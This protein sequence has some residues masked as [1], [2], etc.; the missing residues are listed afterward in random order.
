MRVLYAPN[1]DN[2]GVEVF[3]N[4]RGT[5]GRFDPTQW[6][7]VY[8]DKPNFDI[9]PAIRRWAVDPDHCLGRPFDGSVGS[10][11]ILWPEPEANQHAQCMLS[12]A[13]MMFVKPYQQNLLDRVNRYCKIFRDGDM[14]KQLR[15]RCSAAWQLCYY[16]S[17]PRDITRQ[18]ATFRRFWFLADAWLECR[19][20]L[21]PDVPNKAASFNDPDLWPPDRVHWPRKDL[22]GAFTTD[23]SVGYKLYHR[24]VPVWLLR[25]P[26]QMTLGIHIVATIV[27]FSEVLTFPSIPVTLFATVPVYSGF[28][29][30]R[31]LK[32][33]FE[34]G[35][36]YLDIEH[37]PFA[38]PSGSS[39]SHT[40]QGV[41]RSGTQPGPRYQPCELS[42]VN[43]S[44]DLTMFLKITPPH[45]RE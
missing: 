13:L 16:A 42:L 7:Q 40:V 23:G 31:L 35:H 5:F 28:V 1:L 30:A 14:L 43:V 10:T 12:P 24:G 33:I 41:E 3:Q 6:P 37:T 26:S 45:L 38:A 29:G 27:P 19:V 17:T 44:A 11:D 2:I 39:S 4:D 9:L 32:A 21:F 25:R 22:M 15:D 18:F 34:N 36:R 8:I 20:Y